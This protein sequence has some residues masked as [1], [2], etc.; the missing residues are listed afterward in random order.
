MSRAPI[1]Q[2]A[3]WSHTA[4]LDEV[5][6]GKY[7]TVPGLELRPLDRPARCQS[8]YRLNYRGSFTDVRIVK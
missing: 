3:G 8:L 1:M 2:V 4:C 5:G 6:K 7:F